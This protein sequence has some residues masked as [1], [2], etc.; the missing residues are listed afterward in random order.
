MKIC[1]PVT[2]WHAFMDLGCALLKHMAQTGCDL[3]LELTTEI[4][5]GCHCG[6]CTCSQCSRHHSH[7]GT[8][9]HDTKQSSA[10]QF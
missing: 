9:T 8:C 4:V 6:V 2:D 10:V 3:A 7:A 5:S 1:R